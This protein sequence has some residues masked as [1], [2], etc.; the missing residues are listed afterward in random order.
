M[1]TKNGPA[2]LAAYHK[3]V[4]KEERKY[5]LANTE[6]DISKYP[7]SVDPEAAARVESILHP[8]EEKKQPATAAPTLHAPHG[9]PTPPEPTKKTRVTVSKILQKYQDREKEFG[10]DIAK[11]DGIIASYEKRREELKFK[12]SVLQELIAEINSDSE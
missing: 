4:L 12:L 3:K 9:S 2:T 1:P 6:F 11:I 10:A 7:P 5:I 8:P